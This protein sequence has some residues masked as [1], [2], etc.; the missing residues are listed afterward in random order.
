MGQ[1][2]LLDP[3]NAPARFET[4]K[5]PRKRGSKGDGVPWGVRDVFLMILL[6]VIGFLAAI[7]GLTVAVR[8]VLDIFPDLKSLPTLVVNSL[9]LV[10]QDGVILTISLVFLHLRG[11]R[12]NLATLGF[13]RTGLLMA[14]LLVFT[15]LA[16]SEVGSAI[17]QSFVT[18]QPQPVLKEIQPGLPAL[19]LAIIQIAIIAPIAEEILFRGIIHQG[20]EHQLGFIPA[21]IISAAIFGAAHLQPDIFVP[22]F[23]LGFGFAFLMHYTRSL[24]PSIA[25]HMLFNLLSVIAVYSSLR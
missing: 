23:I 12:F 18:P 24:W 11:Y 21:G 20:L 25:G 14:I 7:L 8:L 19:A 5:S 2:D 22:I 6:A 13:R 17:Y 1:Y 9:F 3:E 16:L 15:V 10:F 4:L